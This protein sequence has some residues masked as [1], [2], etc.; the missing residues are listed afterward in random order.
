MESL[1]NSLK[2][3]QWHKTLT[4]NGVTVQSIQEL[5][6][7]RKKNGEILFSLIQIDAKDNTGTPLLPVVLLRGHFVSVLTC[8]ID[9]ETGQRYL[10]LVKQ[11]R[12]ANGQITYEHPAGM[13]DN[14]TDPWE[15]AIKEVKEETGLTVSKEQLVLLNDK[16]YYSSPGLLD[17]GGYFFACEIVTNLDFINQFQNKQTGAA[18]ESEFIETCLIPYEEVLTYMNNSNAVLNYYLYEDWKRKRSE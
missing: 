15:V 11:I 7:I 4:Q 17:E 3:Q 6:S 13:C 8:M 18:G 9:Q 1:E 10:L 5:Y 14:E 16:L 12:V 2:Y